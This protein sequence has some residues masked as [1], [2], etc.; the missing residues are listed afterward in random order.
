MTQSV[1]KYLLYFIS[2]LL[3]TG[4]SLLWASAPSG[5]AQETPEEIYAPILGSYEL[6]MS[7]FGWGNVN[8]RFFVEDGKLWTQTDMSNG[9]E[10]MLRIDEKLFEF[11]VEDPDEGRYD[12][13]FKQDKAGNYTQCQVKNTSQEIDVTGKKI[14]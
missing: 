8:I 5:A 14:E 12:I 9:P 10:E 7:A 11:M 2:V 13:I 1:Q 4:G 6:D 3:I